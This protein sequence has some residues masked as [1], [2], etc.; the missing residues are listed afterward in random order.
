MPT[1][2]LDAIVAAGRR[3]IAAAA[4]LEALRE[5]EQAHLARRSPLGEVQRSLGGLDADARRR[6]GQR[7]NQARA[8]LEAELAARRGELEAARDAALLEAERLDVTL[9]GRVP[10][11]GA[12]HPVTRT[13][14]EIVDIFVGL[15]YRV[16]EGPEVETDWYNFE[17]LNIPRDHPARSMQDTLYVES[18]DGR[19]AEEL[20]LRTHTSPI[21]IRTMQ[22][23]PP[24]V[25]AVYFGRCYRADTPDATHVPVFNQ[26]EILAVDRGLTMADMKGTLLAYARAFFGEDRDIRL[27][28]SY[29]PFVEP[30]A[31]V[32]V[33]CFICG[34]RGVGC[35]TCRGE[36]WIELLGA[37][38][39]H[40]NV[41]R[42]GGYD[43]D[44]VSG[45]AAGSGVERPFMLRSGLAD[46]RTLTDND[47][48]WL[49]SV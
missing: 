1:P 18:G 19:E 13:I 4:D 28:P 10:P 30:G 22:A 36:G 33:S 12:V 15:G 24:P 29:F 25:Y 46:L 7:V 35:R 31:E 11:R 23:G 38:M 9:P 37:G 48:R 6:L 3:A 47:V 40:P 45:F 21:Q 20:V 44:E 39:V 17:A 42:A 32:D 16:A 14:D 8:T 27:R 41:L 49:T 43:P 34:G 26:I 2:D 5:A